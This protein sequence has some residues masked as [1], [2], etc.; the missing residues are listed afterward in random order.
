MLSR[1]VGPSLAAFGVDSPLA[2]PQVD[3][4]QGSALIRHNAGW[5][6]A[7]A[8]AAAA[9]QV[10]AFSLTSSADSALIATLPPGSYTAQISGVGGATGVALAEVYEMR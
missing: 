4:Y 10:G 7:P 9:A 8:I 2:A 3:L 5:G 6:S 1:G